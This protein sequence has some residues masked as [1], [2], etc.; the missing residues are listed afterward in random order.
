MLSSAVGKLPSSIGVFALFLERRTEHQLHGVQRVADV[1][2][3]VGPPFQLL[4]DAQHEVLVFL[5]HAQG[6]DAHLGEVLIQLIAIDIGAF[7]LADA[8]RV[9]LL[10]GV[11]HAGDPAKSQY[12]DAPRGNGD[13]FPI[14][15][16]V[17]VMHSP[18]RVSCAHKPP[19]PVNCHADPSYSTSTHPAVA[20][21]MVLSVLT[22]RV[23]E[24]NPVR[25]MRNFEP[26]IA[27]VVESVTV[28]L[29]VRT[30]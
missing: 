8:I 25:T 4:I 7:D 6:F 29:A 16:R 21:A 5:M 1:M 2:T 30:V 15:A 10:F 11:Q 28:R 20:E 17:H 9:L 12:E 19:K 27:P 14:G 18:Y 24:P 13:I 3:G 23:K 26:F 22:A